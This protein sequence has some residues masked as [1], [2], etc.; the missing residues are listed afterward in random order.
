MNNSSDYLYS[1]TR[2]RIQSNAE[3]YCWAAYFLFGVLSSLFGDTLILVTSLHTDAFKI[4]KL[5]VTIIQHIAVSDLS[6][7]IVFLLPTAISLLANSWILGTPL[8]YAMVYIMY[9]TYEAG[10][11]L[12]AALTTAKFLILRYPLRA[13]SWS[14]ERAHLVCSI[15]WVY[16][17]MIPLLFLSVD[18]DDVHFDYRP[19]T[20]QYGYTSSYWRKIIPINTF[21][22]GFLPSIVIAVTTVPTLKYLVYARKSSQRVQASVPWQGA[23]TVTLTSAVFSISTLPFAIYHYAA[24]FVNENPPGLFHVHYYRASQFLLMMNVVANFYIYVLTIKSFRT[25]LLSKFR[26]L[27]LPSSSVSTS[28]NNIRNRKLTIDNPGN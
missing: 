27:V 7:T 15:L 25:F 23:L 5:L 12:I 14:T 13:A 22:V 2:F 11:C 9:F 21:F 18:K 28:R 6:T 17:L 19:Y 26:Q 16:S 8:C 10:M 3:R 24:G 1:D 4:N 20:C